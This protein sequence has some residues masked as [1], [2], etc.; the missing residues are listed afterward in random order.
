MFF[1]VQPEEMAFALTLFMGAAEGRISTGGR[2]L[3]T[4][5]NT[6]SQRFFLE[7]SASRPALNEKAEKAEKA[8]EAKGTEE[9]GDGDGTLRTPL[10]QSFLV[11]W[12]HYRGDPS[13]HSLC[14]RTLGFYYA[15][16]RSR[17]AV[18]E[19]WVSPSPHSEVTVE[20][21]SAVIGGLAKASLGPE[22]QLAVR[23]LT[24]AVEAEAVACPPRRPSALPEGAIAV[25]ET[26]ALVRAYDW[27]T[28][29]LGAMRNWPQSLKTAVE[30][31]LACRFPMMVLWTRELVQI[32][33][34]AYCDLMGDK[35]P[36]GMGQRTRDC[37]PEVWQFN[38]PLYERVFRGETMTFEDQFFPIRRHGSMEDAYFTLCYSP[39]RD[40]AYAVSGV[41]VTV[42]ETTE[43]ILGTGGKRTARPDPAK[44]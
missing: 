30:L 21:S 38:Q 34:D 26:A 15:M 27:S 40:E 24:A 31:M 41:L 6:E 19:P 4:D 14:A 28:T 11:L 10:F 7:L 2:P 16:T 3:S 1:A 5:Q 32:Y 39:L 33:N 37:W 29:P 25:N 22:G 36:G 9:D 23:D 17:G 42:F 35:H 12:E 18:L 13:Q 20:L 8:E 43:R 44:A